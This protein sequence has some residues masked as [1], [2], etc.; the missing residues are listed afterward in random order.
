MSTISRIERGR[1]GRMSFDDVGRVGAALD[2]RVDLVPR[3]RGAEL[4]RMLGAGHAVLHELVARILESTAWAM[5]PEASFAI[6][7]E[8]GAIDVLAFHPR[9]GA[10][11]VV[12]LKTDLVDIQGL[13]GAV[14]RYRRLAPIVA[15]QRGWESR[16]VSSWV[17]LRDS[18][19]NHRRLAAHS[20]VLRTAFPDDGRR[21]RG[22]LARPAGA[23]SALSF[24]SDSH[25][26]TAISASAG[27]KRVRRAR[28]A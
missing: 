11:L 6:Y 25:A 22:W 3:W 14:D 24:L 8:R 21:V 16:T 20:T 4:D 26:R 13:I 19:A 7:G 23:I 2:I 28:T 17:V 18:P 10:L 12:E 5:A 27:V 9:S 15:S 1:L